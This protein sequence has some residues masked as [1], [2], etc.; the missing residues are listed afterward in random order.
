VTR[1]K[2][3]SEKIYLTMKDS[4]TNMIN[5]VTHLTVDQADSL[6]HRLKTKTIKWLMTIAIAII[7]LIPKFKSIKKKGDT[8]I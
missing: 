4:L 7:P 5:K 2:S 6:F 1:K 3:N 8:Y